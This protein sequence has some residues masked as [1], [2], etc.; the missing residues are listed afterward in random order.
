MEK[1]V[2]REYYVIGL[3]RAIFSLEC[4]HLGTFSQILSHIVN[5][6]MQL[7]KRKSSLAFAAYVAVIAFERFR[8]LHIQSF[9]FR[10]YHTVYVLLYRVCSK[11]FY[12]TCTCS[13]GISSCGVQIWSVHRGNINI[14]MKWHNA[15]PPMQNTPPQLANCAAFSSIELLQMII[16]ENS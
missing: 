12:S 15:Q 7:C 3:L 11:C 8:M 6:H 14:S 4:P 16:H 5:P 1:P 9:T 10:T 2:L 13:C